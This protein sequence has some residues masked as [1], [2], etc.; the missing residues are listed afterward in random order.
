MLMSMIDQGLTLLHVR[1]DLVRTDLIHG[2]LPGGHLD[3]TGPL[4]GFEEITA[5]NLQY[6][7]QDAEKLAR[8]GLGCPKP[9]ELT[10]K[11]ALI[12]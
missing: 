7:A 2:S 4:P 9:A 11:C 12:C 3:W 10:Q 1:D 5:A 6:D 8:L